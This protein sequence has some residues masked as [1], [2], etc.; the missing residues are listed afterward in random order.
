VW[1][2]L[3]EHLE[4]ELLSAGEVPLSCRPERRAVEDIFVGRW[5][6]GRNTDIAGALKQL[7][8]QNGP[9]PISHAR[10]ATPDAMPDFKRVAWVNDRARA[11]WE[12][13]L[14]R[15]AAAW[16]EIAWLSV[17][18][19]LRACAVV[20]LAPGLFVQRAHAWAGL[21]FGALP[22]S[23]HGRGP[24]GLEAAGNIAVPQQI[25][26]FRVAV[27][28]P[29]DLVALTQALDRHDNAAL[30]GLLGVPACCGAHR[31]M[32]AAQA[33]D[34][35]WPIAAGGPPHDRIG[36]ENDRRVDIEGPWQTNIL[37]RW[38]AV[39]AV[40]HLPCTLG[41]DASRE[42]ADRLNELG[43]QAG[44]DQEM[45]WM[46]EI[47]SW[48]VEWTALHGIAIVSTPIL[49]ISA[50]TD[51]TDRK[52]TVRRHGETYPTEGATGLCFPYRRQASHRFTASKAFGIGAEP[53][54]SARGALP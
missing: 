12:P 14:R 10:S 40:P 32:W 16:T 6:R 43:R 26:S 38:L 30:A 23:M 24:V 18:A 13:R 5:Q 1:K 7:E 37:W 53:A 11:V 9:A 31:R 42:V 8:R 36:D 15:I 49:K 2:G 48:P 21:G 44:Y 20:T 25:D 34:P 3:Y 45:D 47:L 33:I 46:R 51:A 41:C 39:C 4:Q 17:P 29:D 28:A 50:R 27:A 54:V 52:F 19:G 22:L 35:T